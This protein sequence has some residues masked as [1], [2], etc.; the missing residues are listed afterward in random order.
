MELATGGTL[1]GAVVTE[2][3]QLEAIC[4]RMLDALAHAHA[5]GV[6]HR[7]IKPANVL[8]P[9]PGDSP[10]IKLTDFGT[11]HAVDQGLREG[12]RE[13]LVGTVQYAP[14]EQLA[15]RWRDYGPWTDLYAV[16]CLAWRLV[17]GELP[18]V[19]PN[20]E[21]M[22]EAHFFREPPPFLPR[23]PVPD[24]LERWL[25]RL[26]EKEPRR[27]FQRA[28][29]AAWGIRSLGDP[30]DDGTIPSVAAALA[31]AAEEALNELTGLGEEW[32]PSTVTL[33]ASADFEALATGDMPTVPR[34]PWE[35][36]SPLPRTWR[37]PPRPSREMHLVGAGLSLYGLRAVPL[38]GREAERD[39]IWWTLRQIRRDGTAR[40]LLLEGGAGLGKSRLVE[41]IGER[42]HELGAGTVFKVTHSDIPGASDGLAAMVR[43]ALGTTGLDRVEA[44]DRISALLARDGVEEPDE[45]SALTELVAPRTELERA[46]GAPGVVFTSARERH[47]LV[48]R[49]LE[50][51]AARIPVILFLDDVQWGHDALEFAAHLLDRQRVEPSP[52]LVMGTL[53][54][55]ALVVG[56]ATAAL[57]ERTLR[58]PRSERL[59]IAPLSTED[60]KELVEKLLHL[61]GPLA[62]EVASR[63][64]GNPLF[65]VHLVG[66][67]VQRGVL[68]PGRAGFELAEGEEGHVPDDIHAVWMAP[69]EAVLADADSD[70]DRAALELAAA[71]GRSVDHHEWRSVCHVAGVS[72]RRD[73][74]YALLDAGLARGSELRWSFAH[75]LLRESVERGAREA[76]RW[77]SANLHCARM[78]KAAG[79]GP[80]RIASHLLAAG[81]EESVDLLLEAA[82]AEAQSGALTPALRALEQR[83]R[84][85]VRAHLTEADPRWGWGWL[86]TAS[87][88]RRLGRLEECERDTNR[89][90]QAA[91]RHEWPPELRVRALC[92]RAES[93]WDRGR[94]R[95][96]VTVAEEAEA[97]AGKGDDRA[98]IAHS[99]LVLA[100][101]LSA[102][103]DGAYSEA[104]VRTARAEF[105]ALD[106]PIETA[107]CDFA[108]FK[109]LKQSGR[110]S[111]A[112]DLLK[113]LTVSHERGGRRHDYASCLNSL[114]DLERIKGNLRKAESCYRAAQLIYTSIG[115]GEALVVDFRLG[116][117]LLGRR[118]YAEARDRIRKGLTEVESQGRRRVAPG[119]HVALAACA[120]AERDW[121]GYDRHLKG[122]RE[123]Q[124]AYGL[125]HADVATTAR[126]AGDL[127][128]ARR[129]I[130]RAREA[131]E[132]ALVQWRTMDRSDETMALEQL[133]AKHS[134]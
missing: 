1:R 19:E 88:R 71:L 8:L 26:L 24:G 5:R 73:L 111:E 12:L 28:A 21:A 58:H 17:T 108:L 113:E 35:A 65:A 41:W 112:A 66:D 96:A 125:V 128:F 105:E 92:E 67:W 32:Q 101:C 22:V 25:L 81:R 110:L 63:A 127:A 122:A 123:L 18:F 51:E 39:R 100:R 80:V 3:R 124:E 44:A 59:L 61:S 94:A 40:M 13:D 95:Q 83:E 33:H 132:F 68:S 16:G 2:W 47:V 15:G 74:V 36:V 48:R 55:D 121:R 90:L 20:I 102:V 109:L 46:A 11:A 69:V 27:R 134:G 106:R 126:L 75:G 72:P 62:T 99:R 116:L 89:T 56:S 130:T 30:V 103:G 104:L 9:G 6:I 42:A 85:L 86:A 78:L 38:V 97:L 114:G 77:R 60:G 57:V 45:V 10:G 115:S 53:R 133:L 76:G 7:D 84:A 91:A 43:R 4:L 50:R 23:F 93:L 64:A 14:P 54:Q 49:V 29:A 87:I 119:Y 131:W 98:A 70:D 129:R 34:A 52:I 117:V 31:T 118:R 82:V 37:R 107:H 79:A 120:A